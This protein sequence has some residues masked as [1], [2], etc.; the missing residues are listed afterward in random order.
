MHLTG[1]SFP[2]VVLGVSVVSGSS[3][4]GNERAIFVQTVA[5]A[6]CR[7]VLNESGRRMCRSVCYRG[8]DSALE[9]KQAMVK[10]D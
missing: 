8:N 5:S 3:R 1:G 6:G 10:E 7:G 4:G 9:A 2:R